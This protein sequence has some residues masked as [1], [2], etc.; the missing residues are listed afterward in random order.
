MARFAGATIAVLLICPLQPQARIDSTSAVAIPSKETLSYSVE[1]RL[2]YAGNA[3]LKVDPTGSLD[4]SPWQIKLHLESAGLVSK[5]YHLSDNYEVRFDNHFCASASLLDAM[6]KN[7]HH[8]TKVEF[9]RVRG[10]STYLERDLTKNSVIKATESDIPPCVSDIMAALYK[11]RTIRLEPGQS[12]QVLISDGKKTASVRV[13]AQARETVKIKAGTYNTIRY[14]A[15]IFNNVLYNRKGQFYVWLTDDARRLPV[16]IRARMSFPIG[17][18]T[19]ELDK[20]EH[21]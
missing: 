14:E 8:E 21:L 19:L 18:I 5:L 13:E 20:E 15:S 10:K 6:E 12:E 2:I 4:G 7:R 1:W 3:T 11:L 9:D 16:Q 17:S